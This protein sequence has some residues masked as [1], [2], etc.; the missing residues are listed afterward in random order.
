VFLDGT[1]NDEG[2]QTN[3]FRLSQIVAAQGANNWTQ[4]AKYVEGVGNKAFQKL[5]G[6]AV[7]KGLSDNVMAAYEFLV[8][9]YQDGDEI[10]LFGFSRGAYTAR[11]VGGLIASC[12]LR[13]KTAPFGTDWIYER[14][15]NRKDKAT[16]IYEL[17][18]LRANNVRALTTDEE[19][20]LTHS[21]R[22]PIHYLGVWD[23]VGALGI[24]WTGMPLWGKQN[25]YFHNPNLSK[26]YQHAFHALAIDEHRGAYKP[27][28]WT[29]FAKDP[30]DGTAVTAPT[31]PTLNECEQRWFAGAHSD[32][33][34]GGT[35]KVLPL[36]PMAWLQ[37][38]ASQLG[39]TFTTA[40]TAAA[41]EL[42]AKPT[43]SYA[44]FMKGLYRV[45]KF[46]R[47]HYRPIGIRRNRVKGGWSY[48]VNETIDESVFER[49]RV[50]P[51]YARDNLRDWE[52]RVGGVLAQMQGVKRGYE[53]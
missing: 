11:S 51:L 18:Y 42:Q 5:L 6:G 40:I 28:L 34:G 19:R 21:R 24:P 49:C 4:R 14:Y 31:M 20:V 43:D 46:G 52:A 13:Q 33:G 22:V 39:L 35:Q 16:P 36:R 23:T 45:L 50:D 37:D 7:G 8:N 9:E 10:Y 32:V 38:K 25:F 1:W 15:R 30:G 29:K 53:T 17:E 27:T 2:D 41:N 12:G 48:P 26:I 47:R 3:V 44:Q